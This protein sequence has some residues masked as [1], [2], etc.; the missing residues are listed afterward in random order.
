MIRPHLP[1]PFPP[2]FL[3]NSL[4]SRRTCNILR[5]C[6]QPEN[7][8]PLYPTRTHVASLVVASVLLSRVR[9]GAWPCTVSSTRTGT[10]PSS[11]P[12]RGRGVGRRL[13][14]GHGVRRPSRPV[15]LLP[16]RRGRC[17]TGSVAKRFATAMRLLRTVVEER[18]R[19]EAVGTCSGSDGAARS[20]PGA[21]WPERD[22]KRGDDPGGP[23]PLPQLRLGRRGVGRAG[24]TRA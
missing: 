21:R 4:R 6:I 9:G 1:P 24:S 8:G 5:V 20:R 18:H 7:H 12:P 10:S 23:A 11:S 15:L 17:A 19:H 2:I 13:H 14:A 16:H 3:F 22:R